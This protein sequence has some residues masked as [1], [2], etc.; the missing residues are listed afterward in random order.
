MKDFEMMSMEELD[1]ISGGNYV[2]MEK[3]L[4]LFKALGRYDGPIPNII[5]TSNFAEYSAILTDLW[6][7]TGDGVTFDPNEGKLNGYKI[8]GKNPGKYANNRKSAINY[9]IANSGRSLSPKNYL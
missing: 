3:D 5:N 7:N 9:A 8:D 4:K 2:E 1:G 6:K